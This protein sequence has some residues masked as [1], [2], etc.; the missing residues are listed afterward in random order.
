MTNAAPVEIRGTKYYDRNGNGIK[1]G[2]LGFLLVSS[3]NG[4]SVLRYDATTGL[5]AGA[6]VLAGSGGL[7]GPHGLAYGSDGN[8]Y[9]ASVGTNSVL[10]Y[11]GTT[12][13][14]LGTF[15]TPGSGGLA[16]SHGIVFGPDGNLYVA[17]WVSDNVIR[18]NGQTGAFIDVFAAHPSLDGPTEITFGPDGDLY[19]GGFHSDNVLR[20]DGQTGAFLDVFVPALTGGLD[21]TDAVTFGADGDLYVGSRFTN[22]VLRYDGATGAF[23]G[24]FAS[25]GGVN[26]PF[27]VAFGLGRRP[28][29]RQPQHQQR[30]P[31][32]RHHGGLRPG[33]RH[34][35]TEP[36]DLPAVHAA[37]H[38]RPARPR[39]PAVPHHL[40][41]GLRLR[42]PRRHAWRRHRNG[43]GQRR[44]WRRDARLPLLARTDQ[45]GQ[46]HR[47]RR[48]HLRGRTDRRHTDR[49]LR[50]QFLEH[51][52][53]PGLPGRRDQPGARQR[54]LLAGELPQDER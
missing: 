16:S 2:D 31:L 48:S 39:H 41:H 32:R 23:L 14:F 18:Y 19:V 42:R 33:V 1:D 53:Q 6:F 36:A 50:R 25:G 43:H 34:R 5:F 13:A 21:G 38:G 7:V 47:Q 37:G 24:T 15:V 12:G 45:L 49:L 10:R 22:S 20:F 44:H 51:A 3:S 40:Q 28:V 8:L 26:E 46:R 29:R 17:G 9:V 11:N 27:G 54:R 35:R 52:K 4:N 30:P